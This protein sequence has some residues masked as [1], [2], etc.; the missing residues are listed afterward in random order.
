MLPLTITLTHSTTGWLGHVSPLH[1]SLK[2]GGACLQVREPPSLIW[3]LFSHGDKT[4]ETLDG[5]H[6]SW[7]HLTTE[8]GSDTTLVVWSTKLVGNPWVCFNEDSNP[9]YYSPVHLC[10]KHRWE[11]GQWQ[12]VFGW[13]SQWIEPQLSLASKMLMKMTCEGMTAGETKH[14]PMLIEL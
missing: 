8:G 10:W 7:T 3:H 11:G 9:C 6:S 14:V 1:R 13:L 2:R 4:I 12:R 5:G